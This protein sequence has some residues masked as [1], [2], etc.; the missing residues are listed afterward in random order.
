M[1]PLTTLHIEPSPPE[2][3]H[4]IDEF[5]RLN[6]PREVFEVRDHAS[7]R[8][9]K[10]VFRWAAKYG[11]RSYVRLFKRGRAEDKRTL[12]EIN[13]LRASEAGYVCG[14][15]YIH[16]CTQLYC[17]TK[18]LIEGRHYRN[19]KNTVKFIKILIEGR[20]CTNEKKTVKFPVHLLSISILS[21]SIRARYIYC[22]RS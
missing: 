21:K 13:S 17:F 6:P 4:L 8:S 7:W 5:L 19:E 16:A 12:L 15:K 11:F 18:I 20:N 14:T 1:V 3:L 10:N 22:S 9:H 2:F